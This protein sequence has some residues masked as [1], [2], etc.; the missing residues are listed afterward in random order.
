MT[1]T[2]VIG[3]GTAGAAL[4]ARISEDRDREVLVIEAGSVSSDFS[5][6]L[7]DGSN[8]QAAMPGHPANWAYPAQLTPEVPYVIARGRVLGG[9]STI[10]GGYFVLSPKCIDLIEGDQSSW[11]GE[12]LVKLSEQGQLM[13]FE[14]HGFWQP[15]DTLRDKNQLE[16]LWA[17]GK[18][19]WRVWP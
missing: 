9:S 4:A 19:P 10:N 17:S 5:P 3:A 8:V 12:P 18:A 14:H 6:E 16:D 11:E 15:M 7:L 2:I 13:A 1:K